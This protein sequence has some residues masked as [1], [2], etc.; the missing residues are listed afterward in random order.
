KRGAHVIDVSVQQTDRDEVADMRRFLEVLIKKVRAPLMIDS[1]NEK[2]VELALT[3]S[4]GKAI[5][6]SINL[7]DGEK[8]FQKVAPLDRRCA[9]SRRRYRIAKRCWEFQM[10]RSACPSPGARS[11]TRSSSITACRPASIWRW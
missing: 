4:Q 8:R 3:F 1:T 6:N 9:G 11:S 10:S 2:A 5:I 7:E